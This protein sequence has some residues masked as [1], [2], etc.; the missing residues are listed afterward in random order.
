MTIK[1]YATVD[2]D[3]MR[4]DVMPRSV[5]YLLP[6]SSFYRRGFPIPKL[7]IGAETAVDCGGFVATF[8]WGTYRYMPGTY[9]DWCSEVPGLTWAAMFDYCCE[10]EITSAEGAATVI[11]RQRWTTES[12]QHFLECF[13]Y[14]SWSWVPTVQ[15]WTVDDY[16]RHA[17]ALAPLIWEMQRWYGDEV[18]SYDYF[19]GDEANVDDV[20]AFARRTVTGAT[21]RVGIGTLCRRASGKMIAEIVQAVTSILG[22]VP[23]HLWGVK[24]D[25]LTAHN[26]PDNVVSCDSAAWNGRFG[27]GIDART[28]E[29]RAFR[30]T[31]REYG[32]RIALPRYVERFERVVNGRT[33]GRTMPK[34]YVRSSIAADRWKD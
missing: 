23:L 11:E 13:G 20:A 34:A 5:P 22:P 25:Q 18:A 24:L 15:G 6:A 28:N 1:L 19:D 27:A 10:N 16:K 2:V 17:E 21:W 8:K 29:Q 32:Y 7:P 31:Q 26:L 4:P 14:R 3:S 30:M 33:T 12:A 9:D